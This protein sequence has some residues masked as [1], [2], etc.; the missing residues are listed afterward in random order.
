MNIVVIG[1]GKVGST[2]IEQL[3]AEDHDIT[4]I[5][6]NSKVLTDLTNR[7]DIAGVCGNGAAYPSQKQASVEKADLV[8]ATTPTDELNILC[9]MVANQLG[10]K[11]TIAR[12]RNPEY[13]PQMEYL[14]E[15]MGL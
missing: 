10:A 9:C 12:I 15:R 11:H 5:D 1:G 2:L 7:Y 4:V 8:I 3:T 13:A 14:Q 6:T